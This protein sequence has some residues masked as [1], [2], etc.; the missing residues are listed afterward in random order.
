MAGVDAAAWMESFKGY[1]EPVG[2]VALDVKDKV[3]KGRLRTVVYPDLHR[4]TFLYLSGLQR[5][6]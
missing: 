6:R 2:K 5:A 3:G 4:K 1:L